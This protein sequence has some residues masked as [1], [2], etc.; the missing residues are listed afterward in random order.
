M[1]RYHL[2]TVLESLGECKRAY[3]WRM[4]TQYARRNAGVLGGSLEVPLRNGG[5][6]VLKEIFPSHWRFLVEWLGAMAACF[7]P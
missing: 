4:S 2:R 5:E 7:Q 1:M 6:R 3:D